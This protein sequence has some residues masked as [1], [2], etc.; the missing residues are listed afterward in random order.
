MLNVFY[1]YVYGFLVCS[2]VGSTVIRDMTFALEVDDIFCRE[3]NPAKDQACNFVTV[4][5][6]LDA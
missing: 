6:I 3:E 1:V 4:W 5:A 2:K